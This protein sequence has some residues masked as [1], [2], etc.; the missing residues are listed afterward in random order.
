MANLK[1]YGCAGLYVD[2]LVSDFSNSIW[3]KE[4]LFDSII[5]DRK[6]SHQN[7]KL[8]HALR[9]PLAAP[10]GIREATEKIEN[11]ERRPRKIMTPDSIRYPSTSNYNLANL[12][13]DL[14]KFSAKHL[15]LGGRL[16]CW[17]PVIKYAPK[18]FRENPFLI[19][20]LSK[21]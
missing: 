6:C 19:T 7:V 12:Y 1:Q 14:L 10:Y 20:F 13:G 3:R 16:V 5:T 17:I 21:E 8:N 9:C 2:V 15:R 4:M 18:L 11:K